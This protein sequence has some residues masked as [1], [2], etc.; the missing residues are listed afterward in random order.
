MDT[1]NRS[2]AAIET[3]APE[4][5]EN[6][7]TV[8]NF[9]IR[10]DGEVIDLDKGQFRDQVFRGDLEL[11]K[12]GQNK[13]E[14]LANVAFL[15][16]SKTTG[17][18]HVLV[19]DPNGQAGTAS[20]YAAHTKYT[21]GIWFSGETDATVQPDDAKG[22]LP[23]DTYTVQELRCA[24]NEGYELVSYDITVYRNGAVI[25]CGTVDD[26]EIPKVEM[27]TQA[28][29]DKAKTPEGHHIALAEEKTELTDKVSYDGLNSGKTYTLKTVLMDRTTGTVVQDKN[30][31]DISLETKFKVHFWNRSG[32]VEVPVVIDARGLEGH[33]VVFFEYLYDEDGKEVGRHTDIDDEDQSVVFPKAET[34]A[35]DEVTKTN[36][37]L[38]AEDIRV[39]DI[40]KYENLLVGKGYLVTG[41]LMD[42]KTGEAVLDDNGQPVTTSKRFTAEKKDGEVEMLFEFSGVKLA[43]TVMVAASVVSRSW[44]TRISMTRIRPSMSRPSGHLLPTRRPVRRSSRRTVSVLLMTMWRMKPSRRADM[45]LWAH[46]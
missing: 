45:S 38:P 28:S 7:G 25:D 15:I 4:G 23:Y 42:K 37:V 5:H 21:Y 31:K 32:T 10:K 13:K 29:N 9:E 1:G 8:R 19:T 36:I 41:T 34:E 33:T 17:E 44:R 18:A 24:A 11:V 30:G 40:L 35:S 39:K 43:G 22:A 14:R 46:S 20:S 12:A 26:D 3:E 2:Y 16:T 27:A 6:A